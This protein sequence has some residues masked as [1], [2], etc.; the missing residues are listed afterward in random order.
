MDLNRRSLT[1]TECR[2]PLGLIS[3]AATLPSRAFVAG[4]PGPWATGIENEGQFL[5]VRSNVD[6]AEVLQ[7]RT[8][9]DAD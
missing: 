5:S 7:I 2:R 8:I 9:T 6:C 3:V 1:L 4:N